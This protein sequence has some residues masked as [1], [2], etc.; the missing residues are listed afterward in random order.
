MKRFMSWKKRSNHPQM[1]TTMTM[2]YVLLPGNRIGL[3][4]RS[5]QGQFQWRV[6]FFPIDNWILRPQNFR[7]DNTNARI[8]MF[9]KSGQNSSDWKDKIRIPMF[10]KIKLE[11]QCLEGYDQNSNV[12]EEQENN[13]NAHRNRTRISLF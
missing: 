4:L 6:I 3:A 1:G 7:T 12:L 11:F 5:H 8:P 9:A 10:I 13:S 2:W